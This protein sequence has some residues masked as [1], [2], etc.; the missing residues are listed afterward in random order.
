[1]SF[2]TTARYE[3]GTL[4][5]ANEYTP[6]VLSQDFRNA[7]FTFVVSSS[8]NCTIKFYESAQENRPNLWAAVS[9]TNQ[10]DTVAVV[11]LSSGAAVQG[12]TWVVY[13]GSSD[14]VHMYEM[15]TNANTW[16]GC[17]MTA[18]SAGSVTISV[19]LADNS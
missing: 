16:V 1:M 6:M 17:I 10:Y 4:D 15:N 7:I 11:D 8:A 3:L 9:A 13:T 14:W 5:A 2:K 19:S 12:G 18:R